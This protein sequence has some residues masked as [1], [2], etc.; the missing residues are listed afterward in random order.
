MNNSVNQVENNKTHRILLVDDEEFNLELLKGYLNRQDYELITAMDGQTALETVD[1]MPPD[2]ILLDVM[3]PEIDGLEV[4]RRLKASSKYSSIPI[5]II[6]ALD[7]TEHHVGAIEAGADDFIPKPVNESVLMAR[8]RGYLKTKQLS[9]EVKRLME[10][11]RNLTNMVVHDLNNPL[12]SIIGNLDLIKTDENIDDSLRPLIDRAYTAAQNAAKMLEN[13]LS[14]ERMESGM[15]ELNPRVTNIADLVKHVAQLQETNF[16]KKGLSVKL[17][18]KENLEVECDPDL[19]E[20]IFQNLLN[21]AIKFAPDE[22]EI[23][24]HWKENPNDFHLSVANH[25]PTIP[26]EQQ[27]N[28]FDKFA[29]VEN[30]PEITRKGYGLGLAFCKMAIEA[31]SGSIKV[32]SPVPDWEDGVQLEIRIP[33]EY[34]PRAQKAA[35]ES[36][37]SQPV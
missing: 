8:V 23:E 4:C 5:I 12:T 29:Q 21:N 35:N 18:G 27:K 6:T 2:L 11:K 1:N 28:V 36:K 30:R 14:I 31:H 22:S 26:Q 13:L 17:E 10:F 7:D 32:T 15:L 20:R 24:I 34:T 9:D 16:L 25:G 33:I 19:L 3:M 37:I